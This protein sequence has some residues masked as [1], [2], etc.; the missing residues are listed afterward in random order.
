ME[1]D[2][3]TDKNGWKE[4]LTINLRMRASDAFKSIP[5]TEKEQE[6][7][8]EEQE[9]LKKQKKFQWHCRFGF[10]LKIRMLETE[11][12]TFRGLKPVKIFISG[13]PASGKTYY[14]E[15]L[16]HYYN[17]PRVHVGQLVAK[18]FEMANVPEEDAGEDVLLNNCR[19]KIE[20]IKANMTEQ[21]EE[22]RANMEPPEGEEW[23]EIEIKDSDIRVPDSLLQ[24]ILKLKLGEN[25]CRNRGYIL[26]SYPRTFKGAQYAF[27]TKPPKK[28]NADGEE[29][30]EEEEDPGDDEEAEP[31]W[32][33]LIKNDA[34]F[35]G[36]IIV[37][38]GSDEDLIAR[39]RELPEDKI[40]GTHYNEDD[41][42][43]RIK[44]YRLANNSQVAE[45]AVQDFFKMQGIKFFK[46]NMNT[47]TKDALNSF[48]IYIERVSILKPTPH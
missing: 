43:R 12:N 13:P 30:E 17:I 37:M 45:P 48:K 39:V 32:D 42:R 38:D 24:E 7:E 34:I 27:L 4:Q 10:R 1:A 5:L 9:A 22:S 31:N 15:Q 44:D 28:L 6:L 3:V 40:N 26:D 25:D 35:P 33:K 2:A 23:P 16:A 36:S 47:R 41:M 8:E 21:I 29:E 19:T 46:E 11:F 18:V 20:E 14:A